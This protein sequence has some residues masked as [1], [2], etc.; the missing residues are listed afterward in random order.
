MSEVKSNIQEVFGQFAVELEDGA[1]LFPTHAE[2]LAAETEFLK[3]AEFRDEA[4][5]F[6]A[7]QGIEG[8]NA[9]SKVNILVAYFTWVESGRPERAVEEE[10][11][12]DEAASEEVATDVDADEATDEATDEEVEF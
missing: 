5:A 10:A 7:N 9:K 3:G 2:A 12:A 6:C 11:A 4:A 8:K 1:K